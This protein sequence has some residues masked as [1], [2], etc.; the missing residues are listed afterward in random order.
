MKVLRYFLFSLICMFCC[1]IVFAKD[2]IVIKSITPLYDENSTVEVSDNGVIFN[3]KDQSVKYNVVL[4]NITDKDLTIEDISLTKPSQDFLIYKL[5][6]LNKNDVLKA[7]S[8]NEVVV[9]LSTIEKE[10]WGRNFNDEL[11]A[12]INIDSS[13]LNPNTG[14]FV[15]ITSIITIVVI[16]SLV[17]LKNKKLTKYGTLVIAF[18]SVIPF[19]NAKKEIV[20]P[21]KIN[22]SFESQNVMQK[23]SCEYDIDYNETM[24]CDN[25]WAYN[26]QV[27]N[28]YIENEMNRI[29]N[30]AYKF[31]VS[32][33]Q[34]GRVVAYLIVNEED[35]DYYDLH[36]QADGIIYANYDA[37]FYFAD[38]FHIKEI[39]N[40]QGIDTSLVENMSYMFFNIGRNNPNL[41]LD[42]NMF[43]T[44]SVTDMSCMFMSAGG[45]NT[46]LVLDLSNF[47]T[48]NVTDM[49]NMFSGTGYNSALLELDLSNF[50][51]S[52]VIDMSWM[53]VNVGSNDKTFMLDVSGFDTSNVTNMSHMFRGTGY[54]NETFTLDVSNFDTSNVTD[55]SNM[56]SD[57]GYNSEVFTLDVSNFDTSKV[58][59]MGWMFSGTGY[60]SEVFT[61]DVSNFDTSKVTDMNWMFRETGYNSK[62]FT[63][64]VSGFDT[65]KVT[66]MDAMFYKTG[67]NS[68]LLELDVSNFDTSNVTDMRWMFSGT[69]YN[70]PNFTLD[71]SNFDTSNVTNIGCM[72][73]ETGYNNP[74][75]TLDVSNFDTS[76]VTSMSSMFEKT[77][78]N[79]TK[80][81][82]SITIRNPNT[83]SYSGMFSSVAV[84]TGSKI[85]VNYTS[86]TS[87]LVDKMIA[88]RSYKANVFKGVQVD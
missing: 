59:D 77:G 5:E 53:F 83:T 55:M 3:D 40:F 81:N 72:F 47:D 23:N 1:S 7:N 56:F 12:S 16:G 84:K 69:G 29:E 45:N 71:V 70:N 76:N 22:V 74:N 30:Y 75:F 20:I 36:I 46:K 28:F 79:S 13:V 19:I 86:E 61:L 11:T 44:G 54:N 6:G 78:Y 43:D 8:K 66:N 27:K 88:T 39:V 87:D 49:S 10:G 34:N 35:S 82:T 65:S 24:Y 60:N 51:T 64:D 68:A 21:I 14:D 85:T 26:S 33:K 80:L 58:T 32:E 42:F 9:S 50:D 63:L 52:N 57:T 4:E 2:E 41:T 48:S 17:I 25:Y 73:Y 37:S 15:V 31:D 62:N 67:Y 18:F 38:L